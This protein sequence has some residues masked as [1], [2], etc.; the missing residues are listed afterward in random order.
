MNTDTLIAILALS[1]PVVTVIIPTITTYL[2]NIYLI[3]IENNKFINDNRN[4][5]LNNLIN[6]INEYLT[7]QSTS[8]KEKCFL[9]ITSLYCYFD[10]PDDFDYSY[11]FSGKDID[12]NEINKLIQAITNQTKHKLIKVLKNK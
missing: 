9:A 7:E 2:S 10:I 4:K 12:F 1:F 5:A 8:N 6:S 11:I 3:K